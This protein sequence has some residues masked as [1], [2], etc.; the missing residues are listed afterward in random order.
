MGTC[1]GNIDSNSPRK[2]VISYFKNKL[3]LS[4]EQTGN[5]GF[6]S[7]M[8]HLLRSSYNAVSI[9]IMIVMSRIAGLYHDFV[10]L[11][12]ILMICIYHW[13]I[14]DKVVQLWK[15]NSTLWILIHLHLK[16]CKSCIFHRDSIRNCGPSVTFHLHFY[17]SCQWRNSKERQKCIL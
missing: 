4:T 5:M 8:T 10:A 12:L 14:I 1:N 16:M 13:A 3:G 17:F 15:I 7:L 6:N 9:Q 2:N 11:V